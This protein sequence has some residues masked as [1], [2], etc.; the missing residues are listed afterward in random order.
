MFTSQPEKWADR[1][2]IALVELDTQKMRV[3]F[4]LARQAIRDRMR[5]LELPRHHQA[6]LQDVPD[7]AHEK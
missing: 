4:V 1:N 5:E 6:E 7:S 2:I 3:R